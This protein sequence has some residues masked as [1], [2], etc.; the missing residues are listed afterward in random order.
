MV[1]SKG[2][3]WARLVG[4]EDWRFYIRDEFYTFWRL[5][6][7]TVTSQSCLELFP[8]L[9]EVLHGE[10]PFECRIMLIPPEGL[11]HEI[12]AHSWMYEILNHRERGIYGNLDGQKSE[13]VEWLLGRMIAKDAVRVYVKKHYD[14]ELYPADV[15]IGQD[16]KGRVV[17]RG[18]WAKDID[19][20]PFVSLSCSGSIG[21]A[22]AAESRFLGVHV[23]KIGQEEHVSERWLPTD[24]ERD[25]IE[26]SCSQ[27]ESP[28]IRVQLWCAK[29]AVA[30][31]LG[32]LSGEPRDLHVSGYREEVDKSGGTIG[33][34]EIVTPRDLS[35]EYPEYYSGK[36]LAYTNR[37]EDYVIALAILE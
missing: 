2:R 37:Y 22:A 32:S 20:V 21:V 16:E 5:P 27:C 4:W 23:G 29:E 26:R 28:D 19:P 12:W 15:E 33:V 8:I 35:Q 11:G 18:Y 34:V 14:M 24:E 7:R 30:R 3:I 10:Q 36:V 13:K 17:P 31:A 9:R 25:L 1:D 6:D